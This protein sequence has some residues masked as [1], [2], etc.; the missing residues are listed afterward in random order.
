MAKKEVESVGEEKKGGKL[1]WII[2][3]LILL[4]MAGGAAAYWFFMGPG[5][6]PKEKSE[7]AQAQDSRTSPRAEF[8]PEIVSLQPF[9]VNLADPLGRRFLRMSLDVEV[10]NK[11]VASDLQ[12]AD[13]R[14]RDAV[15]L[16]LS[17]KSFSD[18]A[19]MESK[20]ILKNEIMDRLNQILGSGRVTNVYLT[21][22]VIQ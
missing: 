15:I 19:S 4:L 6:D 14:V 13:S 16:L 12:R 3:I 2:L 7:Q 17:G 18:L 22:F 8:I 10:L 20:I 21:E 11:S 1:K 9:I 5:A